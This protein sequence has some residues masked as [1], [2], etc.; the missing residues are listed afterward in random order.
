[1]L[2]L[3]SVAAATQDV[4]ID[5]LCIRATPAQERG[6]LN[7]WMQAGMLTSRAVL[8]G[9]SLVMMTYVG[10]VGVVI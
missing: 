6:S 10:L 9:G 1:M 3:H 2:I 5:A 8:G 4:S 7:G